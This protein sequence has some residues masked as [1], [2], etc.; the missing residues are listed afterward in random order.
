VTDGPR[1]SPSAQLRAVG[2][3]S[4][5]LDVLQAAVE[6]AAVDVLSKHLPLPADRVAALAAEIAKS[7]RMPLSTALLA[8]LNR[9]L[10]Q[11]GGG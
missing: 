11:R 3:A 10:K 1:K 7:A 6:Q 8:R 5:D 4:E 9:Y 2:G